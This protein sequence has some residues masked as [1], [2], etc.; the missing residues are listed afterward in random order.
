MT[1]KHF[2]NFLSLVLFFSSAA[3]ITAQTRSESTGHI[4]PL[5]VRVSGPQDVGL[6][7]G[8]LKGTC[9]YEADVTGGRPPY[10][11]EWY[12]SGVQGVRSRRS[13]HNAYGGILGNQWV[14]VKVTDR[15][16]RKADSGEYTIIVHERLELQADGQVSPEFGDW[17]ADVHF[18]NDS[19]VVVSS[20]TLDVD[21]QTFTVSL[22]VGVS[23]KG[24]IKAAEIAALLESSVEHT[25][26]ASRSVKLNFTLEPGNAI[27]YWRRSVVN[28]TTGTAKRWGDCGLEVEGSYENRHDKNVGNTFTSNSTPPPN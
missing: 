18:I 10:S 5:R 14:L 9:R 27:Y 21:T 28:L 17:I 6:Q 19:D 16:G 7:T 25:T 3:S 11:Y 1:S 4:N 12:L 13:Y 26:T 8:F 2:C 22:K 24:P 15:D 20:E 23:A